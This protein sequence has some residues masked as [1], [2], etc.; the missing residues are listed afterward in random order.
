MA[1]MI[2]PT[3]VIVE[4]YLQRI[5]PGLSLGCLSPS[6]QKTGYI[7]GSHSGAGGFGILPVT[8]PTITGV[9]IPI[10][11][12]DNYPINGTVVIIAQDPLRNASD[13]ML[14]P[15]GPQ[16][17]NPIVGTPFAYHYHPSKAQQTV[18]YRS[19][20]NGLL[21]KGYRVYVTD[22]WKCWDQNKKTRMGKWSKKNPHYQCLLEELN[23]VQPDKMLLMGNV[24]EEKFKT[25][26]SGLNKIINPICVPHP[27][28]A[29]I[30]S[31]QEIGIGTDPNDRAD[32]I[33]RL[34]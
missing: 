26:Q 8:V 30:Q 24:A 29:N 5:F 22:V 1:T 17:P 32:Y 14:Q 2:Y 3:Q 12:E 27:S 25:I 10:L 9:D 28:K 18:V 13:P 33:L 20:I 15:F 11:V 4:K 31:W 6:V 16:F 19:V 23:I 7:P 21:K 34:F